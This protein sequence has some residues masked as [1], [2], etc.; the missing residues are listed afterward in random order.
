MNRKE[1]LIDDTQNQK[2][3]IYPAVGAALARPLAS[4]RQWSDLSNGFPTSA[5]LIAVA[6]AE[7]NADQLVTTAERV[8]E[9]IAESYVAAA[10][11]YLHCRLL[12]KPRS[13]V[14]VQEPRDRLIKCIRWCPIS[15]HLFTA[16]APLY[17]VTIADLVAE[18]GEHREAVRGFF[19]P[20]ILGC[21]GVSAPRSLT[22]S[23][24]GLS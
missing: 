13:H 14:D 10:Q 4:L 20:T 23:F 16:Q 9:L 11:I 17:S 22:L 6:A 5:A 19:M 18:S 12:K 8:N 2:S 1:V 15:G 3:A 7:L 21:R 24:R